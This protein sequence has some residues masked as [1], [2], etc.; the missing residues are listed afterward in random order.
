MTIRDAPTMALVASVMDDPERTADGPLHRIFGQILRKP[1]VEGAAG[2]MMS[3]DSTDVSVEDS[4]GD[5]VATGEYYNDDDEEEEDDTEDADEGDVATAQV[6]TVIPLIS[7]VERRMV[8][9][10]LRLTV[11]CAKARARRSSPRHAL[12]G[13]ALPSLRHNRLPQMC[14]PSPAGAVPAR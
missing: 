10:Q 7:I 1:G 13:E 2:G 8:D 4:T 14:R 6:S 3:V 5:A 12:A 9:S 11:K